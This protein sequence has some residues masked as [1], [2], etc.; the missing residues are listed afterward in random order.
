MTL[1]HLTALGQATASTYCVLRTAVDGTLTRYTPL[2]ATAVAWGNA[3]LAAIAASAPLDRIYLSPG[4]FD[5]GSVH[6]IVMQAFQR[7]QGS[8]SSVT[9]IL[10]TLPNALG[11]LVLPANYCDISHLTIS[12]GSGVYRYGYPLGR[13][14][15]DQG[16]VGVTVHDVRITGYSDCLYILQAPD[17]IVGGVTLP[18]STM[19][20]FNCRLS[21]NYDVLAVFGNATVRVFSP[22]VS[23]TPNGASGS[24]TVHAGGTGR[25]E[26]YGGS[27]DVQKETD[28][29]IPTGGAGALGAYAQDTAVITLS[30]VAIHTSNTVSGLSHDLWAD[31]GA[32]ITVSGC[33]YDPTKTGGPGTI[34][35]VINGTTATP[36]AL[37]VLT[38]GASSNADA[39]H[40]HALVPFTGA[41]AA[42]NLGTQNLSA[43][44]AVIPS[45]VSV[46][47][48]LS[49][50]MAG[51][52][53]LAGFDVEGSGKKPYYKQRGGA[54]YIWYNST[55]GAYQMGP[56][57]LKV[58]T[59]HFWVGNQ[60][61]VNGTYSNVGGT[62]NPTVSAPSAGGILAKDVQ[63]ERFLPF[64]E[65]PI[66]DGAHTVGT[67]TITTKGGIILS[68]A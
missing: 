40:T 24:G 32:T 27:I 11:T 67:N 12:D 38:A 4:V 20:M 2:A 35:A 17:E 16:F 63:A 31:A 61:A 39:Q 33:F 30:G 15:G 34:I 45:S 59:G 29:G 6:R 23:V 25:I 43:A 58:I 7:L 42:L 53:D 21:A 56:N 52:Y 5:L 26:V 37:T 36:A 48:T 66:A 68:I 10:G 55:G 22:T 9:T 13:I 44:N 47:G 62:G 1:K 41:V 28:E 49:D 8:G 51:W 57:G 50:S 19:D 14:I 65:T 3:L 46:T 54:G 64:G 60:A 18:R